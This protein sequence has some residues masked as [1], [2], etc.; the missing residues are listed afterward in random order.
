MREKEG[1][2]LPTGARIIR[3]SGQLGLGTDGSVP[4]NFPD[5]PAISFA[6]I[7]A[8]LAEGGT[9]VEDICHIPA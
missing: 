5:Q 6:N 7:R 1:A 9:G 3:S 2:L 4:E 8:F